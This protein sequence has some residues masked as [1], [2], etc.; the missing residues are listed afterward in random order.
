LLT[1]IGFAAYTKATLAFK[2]GRFDDMRF[3][4]GDDFQH[5]FKRAKAATVSVTQAKKRL[6]KALKTLY[7]A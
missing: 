6:A 7:S 4:Q 1:A 2:T 5:L 3:M